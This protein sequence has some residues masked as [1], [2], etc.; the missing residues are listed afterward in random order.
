MSYFPKIMARQL[1]L[2]EPEDYF[3]VQSNALESLETLNLT[4]CRSLSFLDPSSIPP[5]AAL[6]HLNMSNIATMT[7]MPDWIV[8]LTAL[9]T[10]NLGCNDALTRLHESMGQLQSLCTLDLSWCLS[11]TNLPESI[12]QLKSLSSLDLSYCDALTMLPES[13]T[14][15]ISLCTLS[16]YRCKALERLPDSLGQLKS[17]CKLN[18]SS[19][20]TLSELPDSL[21]HLSS[22]NALFAS[23]CNSLTR[24]PESLGKLT[25]LR[26][27]DLNWSPIT[28]LPL[29]F[30]FLPDNLQLCLPSR[31]CL[32]FPP[33]EV[34][35]LG[36]PA[37]RNYLLRH[38]HPLKMFLLILAARRRRIRHLPAELWVLMLEEYFDV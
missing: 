29:S 25:S 1:D 27:L 38:N 30:A 22:L 14:R 32:V 15:L 17:L 4:G 34:R 11:L 28:R 37:V 5:L 33:E 31:Y 10:L 35:H 9:Q 7:M 18:I 13:M 23:H 21:G 16:L 3:F 36:I 12:N 26:L 19:C 24:L 8:R 6:K 20:S 2:H